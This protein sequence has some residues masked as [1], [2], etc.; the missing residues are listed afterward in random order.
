[1]SGREQNEEH[2]VQAPSIRIH[3]IY[4]DLPSLIELETRVQ[5][6]EWAGVG[7]VYAVPPDILHGQAA[8]LA[9]WVN[10]P[11]G[12]CRIEAGSGDCAGWLV[13]RFYT[14][15]RVKHVVCHVTLATWQF[16]WGRA[17]EESRLSLEIPTE[18]G[19]VE[20]F[21]RHLESL[22]TTLKGEALLRGVV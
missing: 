16:T 14:V 8:A 17:G 1:M 6:G 3:V 15:D 20:R 11:D 7:R 18:L 4:E 9:K 19:L 22:V 13:L 21:A 10:Q 5:S 2:M 12:E